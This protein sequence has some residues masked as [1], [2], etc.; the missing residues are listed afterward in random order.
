MKT[1]TTTAATLLLLLKAATPLAAQ[2]TATSDFTLPET[3]D[4]PAFLSSIFTGNVPTVLTGA[5]ATSVVSSLY[6]L[7]KSWATHSLQSSGNAAIWSAA[8][9]APDASSVEASL[10]ASGY[11]YG[12][13]TTNAWYQDNVPA[14]IKSDIASYNSAWVSVFNAVANPTAATKTSGNAAA[15]MP[16]CTGMAVAAGAVAVGVAAAVGL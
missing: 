9:K 15:G 14:D 11:D 6:S 2:A 16:A 12:A 10:S 7:E 5:V 4:V 3:T 8:G 1:L 13:I